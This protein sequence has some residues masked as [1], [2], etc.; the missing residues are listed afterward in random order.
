MGFTDYTWSEI[1]EFAAKTDVFITRSLD[2]IAMAE[3][4]A[5]RKLTENE[6]ATITNSLKQLLD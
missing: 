4:N 6:I 1:T 2:D 5:W 3:L